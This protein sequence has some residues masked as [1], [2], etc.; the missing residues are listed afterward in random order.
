MHKKELTSL[1]IVIVLAGVAYGAWYA[2]THGFFGF[3]APV[4]APQTAG[5]KPVQG[6]VSGTTASTITV[7]VQDGSSSTYTVDATTK[8]VSQVLAGTPGEGLADI[9]VGETVLLLPQL[10]NANVAASINLFTPP[11]IPQAASLTNVSGSLVSTSTKS[12]KVQSLSD[13]SVVTINLT[14]NTKVVANV[15]AGEMAPTLS[16]V[17]KGVMLSVVGSKNPDGSVDAYDIQILIPL[18][19]SATA[20]PG[21]PAR[22]VPGTPAP[23]MPGSPVPPTQPSTY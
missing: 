15:Q 16:T 8:I 21:T 2:Q 17:Y 5:P 13:S 19:G 11:V 22:A 4:P 1:I 12:I 7:K 18:T 14:S 9:K 3:K 20:A 23:A 10:D 6:T